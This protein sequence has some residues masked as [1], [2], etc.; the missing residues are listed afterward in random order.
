MCK[1][2]GLGEFFSIVLY[3]GLWMRLMVVKIFS[4]EVINFLRLMSHVNINDS[5]CIIVVTIGHAIP[6]YFIKLILPPSVP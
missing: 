2:L 5:Q 3:R 4:G 6:I 1:G